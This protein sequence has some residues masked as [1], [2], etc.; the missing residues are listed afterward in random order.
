MHQALQIPSLLRSIFRHLR[1]DEDK[2]GCINAALTCR[3]FR[4]PAED[5][6]WRELDC[7]LVP[8]FKLISNFKEGTGSSSGIYFVRG[9]VTP[10]DVERM[11]LFSRRVRVLTY[12]ERSKLGGLVDSSAAVTIAPALQGQFLFPNLKTLRCDLQGDSNAILPLCISPGLKTLDIATYYCAAI[13]STWAEGVSYF[14]Q[15]LAD[16]NIQLF[17]L[18]LDIPCTLTLLNGVQSSFSQL[19]SLQISLGPDSER[20]VDISFLRALTEFNHLDDL[21]LQF[22]FFDAFPALGVENHP[23]LTFKQVLQLQITCPLDDVLTF[24]AI[25]SFPSLA[26]FYFDFILPLSL[27]TSYQYDWKRL[28][29]TIHDMS[30]PSIVRGVSLDPWR[31]AWSQ[32][33]G[34]YDMFRMTNPG[35]AFEDLSELLLRFKLEEFICPF[36]LFRSLTMD[37]L[38]SITNAWEKIRVLYLFTAEPN[39]VGLDALHHIASTLPCIFNLSMSV[40]ASFGEMND[41]PARF[42]QSLKVLTLRFYRYNEDIS[43]VSR[44]AYHVDALF[45]NINICYEMDECWEDNDDDGTAFT[46]LVRIIQKA[47]ERERNQKTA[48]GRALETYQVYEYPSE[49]IPPLGSF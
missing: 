11:K 7:G 38:K 24:L 26:Y 25:T 34:R 28:L 31:T 48:G 29:E 35:V 4:D 3:A 36:P 45:P 5:E 41:T 20:M 43:L 19:R 18:R 1:L 40:N 17:H 23:K 42:G 47:R 32:N 8:L 21:S 12:A 2:Q 16:A 10:V 14:V 27:E 33:E 6:L 44:L 22:N 49:Q 15:T 30:S 46:Q 9:A 37:D 13:E 39:T